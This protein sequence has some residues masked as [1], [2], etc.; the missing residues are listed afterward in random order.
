V[1]DNLS[2]AV[3]ADTSEL[4]AQLALAQA[5]L[6]AFGGDIKK[7]AGDIRGGGRQ[8]QHRGDRCAAGRC[9]RLLHNTH[10]RIRRIKG[11]GAGSRHA[12][13]SRKSPKSSASTALLY[14]IVPQPRDRPVQVGPDRVSLEAFPC[15]LPTARAR[16]GT[17]FHQER[18]RRSR[19]PVMDC[20]ESADRATRD[21]WEEPHPR[22]D[23]LDA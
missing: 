3:T 8:G 21:R 4:R 20:P 6:K 7:L 10:G 2:V 23:L 18:R 19:P 5:D 13:P 14:F 1:A 12:Y 9:A 15:S 16:Q 11:G 17:L 22:R